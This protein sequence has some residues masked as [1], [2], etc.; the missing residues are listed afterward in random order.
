VANALLQNIPNPVVNVTNI[1]FELA[2]AGAA[3]LTV[4]DVA[5]RLVRTVE[6]DGVAGLNRVEVENL[7]A[8][9]VYSYTLTSG[10]FTATRQMVVVK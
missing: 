6:V 9:G 8:A 7:G 10:N 5:G 1:S 3:T 4:Q 2:V